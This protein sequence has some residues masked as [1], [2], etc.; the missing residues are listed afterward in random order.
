MKTVIHLRPG[1]AALAAARLQRAQSRVD[2]LSAA[3]IKV[4]REAG[5]VRLKQDALR[6]HR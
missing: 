6:K 3:T 2:A 5:E 1:T 4:L